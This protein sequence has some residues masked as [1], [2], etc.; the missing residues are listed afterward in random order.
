MF[1]AASVKLGLDYAVMHNMHHI[2][3][4]SADKSAQTFSSLSRRELENLLKHGAYG[5]FNDAQDICLEDQSI[6]QIL[7]RS[8]TILRETNEIDK[9]A[10]PKVSFSRASFV[11]S[12]SN[13]TSVSVDDPDF[14]NKVVGLAIKEKE[15]GLASKRKCR[16]T[17]GSYKEPGM[18]VKGTLFA[19]S[20]YD[21]DRSHP[22][23]KKS[24]SGAVEWSEVNLKKI[25]AAM[26]V[27]GYCNPEEVRKDAKLKWSCAD[28]V[29]IL[30]LIAL[31]NTH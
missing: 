8:S 25:L 27:K 6:E 28:I 22:K 20:D 13:E 21:S 31:I 19:E 26:L 9:T 4:I 18:H 29:S 17:V 2:E 1:R 14:W 16:E 10:E 3:G 24:R 12:T 11:S 7:S 5:A 23:Q 15:D 30:M